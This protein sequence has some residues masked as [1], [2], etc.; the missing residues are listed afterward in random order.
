M[1]NLG[2]NW[3]P[4]VRTILVIFKRAEESV[5]FFLHLMFLHQQELNPNVFISFQYFRACFE[6]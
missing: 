1:K 6:V 3:G 4:L 5:D 2:L